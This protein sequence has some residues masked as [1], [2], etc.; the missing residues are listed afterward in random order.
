MYT[1]C[2]R[3]ALLIIT[4]LVVPMPMSIVNCAFS[5]GIIAFNIILH[6]VICG[7]SAIRTK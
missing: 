6:A 5:F 4:D 3:R 7:A 2:A 1:V